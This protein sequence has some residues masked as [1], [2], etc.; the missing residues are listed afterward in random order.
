[1]AKIMSVSF[2]GVIEGSVISLPPPN[3][4]ESRKGTSC[5]RN[6]TLFTTDGDGGDGDTVFTHIIH[7]SFPARPVTSYSP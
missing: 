7:S 4:S 3:S 6:D 2:I 1:M 5:L